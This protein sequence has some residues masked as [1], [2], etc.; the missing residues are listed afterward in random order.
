MNEKYEVSIR[1]TGPAGGEVAAMINE[2]AEIRWEWKGP[3]D[4][5]GKAIG[6]AITTL[7]EE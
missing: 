3:R 1:E 6:A 7:L 2:G 4:D 5:A